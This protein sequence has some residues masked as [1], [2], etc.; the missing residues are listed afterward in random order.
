MNA[1]KR[2]M[3]KKF[4]TLTQK[5]I[6]NLWSMMRNSRPLNVKDE[7]ADRARIKKLLDDCT[8]DGLIAKVTEGMD[9]DCSKYRRV[10]HVPTPTVMA[11]VQYCDNEYHY[12]DGPMRIWVARPSEEPERS[13]SRDL[14]LE[15]FEDGHP[16]VVYA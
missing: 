1:W 13:E 3:A 9:C 16:H 6:A 5:N 2:V 10:Y 4:E 15:A 7:L 11:W 12:A 14:A 8:E